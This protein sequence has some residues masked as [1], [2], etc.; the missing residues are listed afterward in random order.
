MFFTVLNA[1]GNVAGEVNLD[2][3]DLIK[4]KESVT[5]EPNKVVITQHGKVKEYLISKSS[6]RDLQSYISKRRAV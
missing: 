5:M 4:L 3:V 2:N 1:D 6:Y